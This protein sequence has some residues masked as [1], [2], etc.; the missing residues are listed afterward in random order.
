MPRPKIAAPKLQVPTADTRFHID[1]SWWEE[2]NLDLE[3]YV[4]SR[5]NVG[6]ENLIE[7]D[8]EQV[9]IIDPDTGEVRLVNGFQYVLQTYFSQQEDDFINTTSFVDAVFCV[10]LANA[11]RPMTANQ[12]AKRVGR[13]ADV[14]LKTLSGPTVYQGI[15]PLF[16]ED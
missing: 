12:I 1:Y 10:L 11:N 4:I 9:D 2:S 8:V 16:D 6:Q 5:L 14:V 15:R 13:P 3:A 7:L